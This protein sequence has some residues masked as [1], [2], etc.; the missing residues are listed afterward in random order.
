MVSAVVAVAFLEAFCWWYGRLVF[1][2]ALLLLIQDI[3][4]LV[5][6][7]QRRGQLKNLLHMGIQ[8]VQ[9]M[10]DLPKLLMH[11]QVPAEHLFFKLGT[12][13]YVFFAEL[14]M[15]TL[16]RIRYIIIK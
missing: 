2:F 11:F 9:G 1:L 7:Q 5:E 13:T 4:W 14:F 3:F 8:E 6:I 15:C 12:H 10:T 16:L